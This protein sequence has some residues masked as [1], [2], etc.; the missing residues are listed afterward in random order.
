MKTSAADVSKYF[1]NAVSGVD[2]MPSADSKVKTDVSFAT[3]LNDS[4]QKSEPNADLSKSSKKTQVNTDKQSVKNDAKTTKEVDDSKAEIRDDKTNDISKE[5]D[6]LENELNTK[7]NEIKDAIKDKFEVDDEAIEE[8]METLNLSMIDLLDPEKLKDLIM[9]VTGQEDAVSL[10]TNEELYTDMMDIVSLASDLSEEI[11]SEFL[12]QDE[13]FS[14][15]ISKGELVNEDDMTETVAEISSVESEVILTD[16]NERDDKTESKAPDIK[17]EI[18][19]S[20]ESR[21][22]DPK[23]QT[24]SGNINSKQ[25]QNGQEFGNNNESLAGEMMT[26]QTV[27]TETVTVSDVVE[28]VRQFSSYVDGNEV[29]KQVTEFVKV[30]I[31][32]EVTSMELQLHPA[33]LGTV[34]MNIMSQNG[35]VTAQ[36][37]VQNESVKE[38]LEA[39]MIQLQQIFEE[40]GTKVEAVEVAV[41]S[42]D[43]DRGPFQDRD[44]RQDRQ[45]ADRGS[46]RKI[47]LNL[48][49]LD[50]EEISNLDEENQLARHV[51]EMNGTSIDFSA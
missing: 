43:L 34:N 49:D 40:Q 25:T 32:P 14:A 46:H 21:T 15:L 13:E 1:T 39:Q 30:N 50:D 17:V 22:S 48:N 45:N 8:A 51:M 11:K 29:V 38:A 2:K 47:N 19:V 23:I 36:L 41:A 3:Y 27:H 37:L 6:G 35:A 10:L 12:M 5:K 28:T 7:A 4:S 9:N 31:S 18:N 16:V 26:Q 20:E 33:S 42:Y 24:V 44:D